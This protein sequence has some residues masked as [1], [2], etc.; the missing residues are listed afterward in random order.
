MGC[1]NDI[2]GENMK[3]HINNRDGKIELVNSLDGSQEFNEDHLIR[4]LTGLFWKNKTENVNSKNLEVG[5]KKWRVS[6]VDC[7][8]R[9][10]AAINLFLY[11]NN[12]ET[13][14]GYFYFIKSKSF[15]NHVKIGHSQDVESRLSQ[16]QTAT[17]FRDFYIEKYL[18]CRY[19]RET[20]KLAL[21]F[22]KDSIVSGEWINSTDTG[23]DFKNFCKFLDD[24]GQGNRF[25]NRSLQFLSY[26]E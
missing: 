3:V 21:N 26:I 17:P 2:K 22:F 24:C 18:I 25:S 12:I 10:L 23:S 5:S 16:Y 7:Y 4:E 9:A 15:P 14:I 6:L 8:E 11:K 20:E 19:S 1:A 13:K